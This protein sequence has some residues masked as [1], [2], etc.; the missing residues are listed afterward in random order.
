MW[1]RDRCSWCRVGVCE[2]GDKQSDGRDINMSSEGYDI[3]FFFFF[4]FFFQAE[5]GIQD[6]CLSR[7]LGDV[8]KEQVL[9][10]WQPWQGFALQVLAGH[11]ESAAQDVPAP[12]HVVRHDDAGARRPTVVPQAGLPQVHDAAA[13]DVSAPCTRWPTVVEQA[14]AHCVST[15]T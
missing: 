4:Y 10:P 15:P 12:E 5:D 8:Y 2:K 6:F 3:C 7:G 1:R 14:A 13:Q 11:E 9:R